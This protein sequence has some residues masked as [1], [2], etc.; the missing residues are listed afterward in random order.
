MCC[1]VSIIICHKNNQQI[2][3]LIAKKKKKF[4]LPSWNY[5]NL[6]VLYLESCKIFR[7]VS[8]QRCDILV[9]QQD[10]SYKTLLRSNADIRLNNILCGVKFKATV[11]GRTQ[12][13]RLKTLNHKLWALLK[14]TGKFWSNSAGILSICGCLYPCLKPD[15]LVNSQ[16]LMI[17]SYYRKY[18]VWKT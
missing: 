3:S 12:P 14:I 6:L 13:A 2:R 15:L 11:F 16:S 18:Q 7:N 1:T 17:T 5:Q 4:A 10:V 9:K 8:C